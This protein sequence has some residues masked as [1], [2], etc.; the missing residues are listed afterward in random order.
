[1]ISL[2]N[3]NGHH[4]RE[5]TLFLDSVDNAIFDDETFRFTRRISRNNLSNSSRQAIRSGSIILSGNP[6]SG[7]SEGRTYR[8]RDQKWL[9]SYNEA[10]GSGE[11]RPTAEESTKHQKTSEESG[12]SSKKTQTTMVTSTYKFGE[13]LEFW[14]EKVRKSLLIFH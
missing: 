4:I 14:T 13:T 12:S 2:L 7:S 11:R 6:S 9:N 1:M 8:I 3:I 5:S 10:S